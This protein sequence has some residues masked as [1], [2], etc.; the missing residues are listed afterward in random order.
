MYSDILRA[1]GNYLDHEV[2]LFEKQARVRQVGKHEFLLR[3]GEVARSLYY[4]LEGAVQQYDI[5]SES[6]HNVI[7]LHVAGEWFL[8]YESLITQRPSTVFME[9]FADSRIMEISLEAVHHLTGRSTAFLQ[10]N[11]VLEGAFKRMQFFDQSMTPTEKYL[12]VLNHSPQLIHAFPLKII[13]S[14]LKVTP[15]TLSRVR[16]AIANGAVS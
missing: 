13:A 2:L 1:T 10:L 9:A 11:R 5:V 12:S 4:L 8:N 7:N 16:N 3:K 15:E 6:E 14:Y